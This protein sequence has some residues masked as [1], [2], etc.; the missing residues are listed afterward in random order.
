MNRRSI[1]LRAAVLAVLWVAGVAVPATAAQGPG[2]DLERLRGRVSAEAYDRLAS[3]VERARASGLPTDPLV[4]KAL[5][6]VAKR[7]PEDRILAVVERLE[8]SLARAREA[9]EA[10]GVSSPA[11]SAIVGV[12]TA[13]ERGVPGDA[14]GATVAAGGGPDPT[15]ALNTVADLIQRGVPAEDALAMV[16][17]LL[18]RGGHARDLVELPAAIDRLRSRGLGVPDAARELLRAI[19]AGQT[20]AGV[21]VPPVSVPGP[22]T[23]LPG[24]AQGKPPV[25][26]P[27]PPSAP[28][29][30]PVPTP[31]GQ[32][33][34]L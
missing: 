34:G 3:A 25:T 6:G 2:P 4:S 30:P 29:R 13:F 20:P 18:K 17:E 21:A 15:V 11:P 24:P 19:R 8:A 1:D 22:P 33:P 7:V 14:V 28:P 10:A 9:L 32:V 27:G 23:D 12:A 5:E 31:P 26:P 16:V